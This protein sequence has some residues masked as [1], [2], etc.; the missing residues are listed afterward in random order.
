MDIVIITKAH[1][2]CIDE[3]AVNTARLFLSRKPIGAVI[4]ATGSLLMKKNAL[5]F[6]SRIWAGLNICVLQSTSEHA[7]SDTDINEMLLQYG[8]LLIK[9]YRE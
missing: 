7:T 1:D 4:K 2:R 5:K 6:L 3:Q 8:W 9:L